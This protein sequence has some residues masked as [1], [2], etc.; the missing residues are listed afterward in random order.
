MNIIVCS[1]YEHVI[2]LHVIEVINEAF[3]QDI[4][5]LLVHSKETKS[6]MQRL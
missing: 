4:G 6:W 5:N 1:L 2:I 3:L